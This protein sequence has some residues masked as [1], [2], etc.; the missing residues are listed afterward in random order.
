MPRPRSS[1]LWC[2]SSAS[3]FV[4]D[5]RGVG[6]VAEADRAARHLVLV[7]RADAAPGGADAGVAQR[8]LAGAVEL[9]VQ[10][11]DQRHVLGDADVVGADVHALAAQ[12]ARSRR[13][14]A[15][16]SSTTPLPM[17]DSLPGRTTPDGSRLSL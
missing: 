10:R 9:A 12:R 7:G 4:G 13:S 2:S 5:H 8:R 15:Q 17:I 16:G 14:S 6:E 3:S 11:Q 1:A